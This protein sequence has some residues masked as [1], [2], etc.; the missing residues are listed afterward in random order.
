MSSHSRH[1]RR[2]AEAAASE[3]A[4][5]RER[6][7]RMAA[8]ALVAATTLGIGAYLAG[9]VFLGPR[10]STTVAAA[11]PMRIS[12]AGFDPAV[13]TARPG[14]TVTL[15]WWNTDGAAHLEGGVHT[16]VSDELGLRL[17]LPA[18]SRRTV[19]ISAPM[20]PGDYDFWCDSCCG[21]QASPS[22]HG[23]LRVET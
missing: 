19:T 3:A 16:L 14:E 17:E 23:R 22:M 9:G 7:I 11:I 4:A 2:A 6:R 12:M 13:I 18:Q 21:G 8:F 1:G 20:A 15:D 10:G 5:L